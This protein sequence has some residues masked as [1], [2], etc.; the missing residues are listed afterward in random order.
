MT[1][2]STVPITR[3]ITKIFSVVHPNTIPNGRCFTSITEIMIVYTSH[4]CTKFIYGCKKLT[5]RD[6]VWVGQSKQGRAGRAG[7]ELFNDL[8]HSLYAVCL[9]VFVMLSQQGVVASTHFQAHFRMLMSA[10]QKQNKRQLYGK[11]AV[12]LLHPI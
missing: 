9:R 4:H 8:R 5:Y 3:E 6:T 7:Y 11:C 10:R 2:E 1:R 12:V